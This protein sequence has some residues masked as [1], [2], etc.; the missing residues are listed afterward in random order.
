MWSLFEAHPGLGH[1]E[2]LKP[3]AEAAGTWDEVRGR[4]L[5]LLRER[6]AVAQDERRARGYGWS[7]RDATELVRIN[8]WE[9]D[10]E[11]ALADAREG[12]CRQEVWRALAEALE[13]AEPWEAMI[14]YREQVE[15]TIERRRKA[16]YREATDMLAKVRDLMDRTGHGDEFPAY[17]ET[18]RERHRR[19]RNLMKLLQVLEGARGDAGGAAEV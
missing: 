14:I 8:L 1:L 2:E 18:V 12:G 17:L 16:D 6:I 3:Y 4:A 19:K 10:V 7:H 5:D 13:E 15:S 11:A 9:G